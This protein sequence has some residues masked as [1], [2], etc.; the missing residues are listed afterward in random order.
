MA[1]GLYQRGRAKMLSANPT[2]FITDATAAS[3]IQITTSRM[4]GLTTGDEVTIEGVGGVL[5]ANGTFEIV[6]AGPNTTTF[7]LVGTSGTET[8][9]SG[10]EVLLSD[11][12]LKKNPYVIRWGQGAG[13]AYGD[14]IKAVLVNTVAGTPYTVNLLT[15][16][17]L[18]EIAGDSRVATSANFT[19][20]VFEINPGTYAGGVAD[21]ADVVFANVPANPSGYGAIEALVIYKDTGDENTSPLIAY[22]D[23]ATGLP[24]TPNGG[25]ITVAWDN[26]ANRIFKI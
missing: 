15:H 20:K 4:H 6:T 22:I 24:V 3:P 7:T 25:N 8:Y 18:S 16:E 5:E 17:Y 10:G 9:T 12:L 26:G 1:N 23:T 11:A 13:V 14:D 2:L 21:A 19:D